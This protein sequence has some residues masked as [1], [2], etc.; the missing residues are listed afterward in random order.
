[1]ITRFSPAYGRKALDTDGSDVV[2]YT[3]ASKDAGSRY[4][5]LRRA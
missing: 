3:S 1:M 5:I 2:E 4:P